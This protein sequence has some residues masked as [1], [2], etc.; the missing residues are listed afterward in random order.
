MI[1]TGVVQVQSYKHITSCINEHT[2]YALRVKPSKANVMTDMKLQQTI[3]EGIHVNI[4]Y[5]N[6]ITEKRGRDYAVAT[7]TLCL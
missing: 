1:A 6:L 4:V 7:I 2:I 3:Q 5:L